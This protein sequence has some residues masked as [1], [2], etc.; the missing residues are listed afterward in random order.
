[1]VVG[2]SIGFISVSIAGNGLV[3][4]RDVKAGTLLL[5]SKAYATGSSGPRDNHPLSFNFLVDGLKRP[6]F[7]STG[8]CIN[9]AVQKLRHNP[10]TA[11]EL[12][13][14]Y[15]GDSGEMDGELPAEGVIDVGRIQR[16]CNYNAFGSGSFPSQS[17][18]ARKIASTT[19]L[20]LLPSFINHSCLGND[21]YWA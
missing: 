16:I 5:V 12:H 7:T 15:A 21:A 4:I 19:E 2:D 18:P 3:A 20:W 1:M 9:N 10:Q 6:D 14:L 17:N 8:V 13:S 11:G